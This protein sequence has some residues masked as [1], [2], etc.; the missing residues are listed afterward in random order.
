MNIERTWIQNQPPEQDELLNIAFQGEAGAHT[1]VI[2]CKTASGS[3]VALS[4][5][6]TGVYLGQNNVTV[7]LTGAISDGKAVVTLDD[8]CYAIP[9]KFIVSIYV[10]SDGVRPCVY[11]GIGYMFRTQTT[12][13]PTD[14]LPSVSEIASEAD[15]AETAADNAEASAQAAA[16]S[17]ASIPEFAFNVLMDWYKEEHDGQLTPFTKISSLTVDAT[18]LVSVGDFSPET[19]S[20]TALVKFETRGT[21]A[22]RDIVMDNPNARI[23]WSFTNLSGNATVTQGSSGIL[24]ITHGTNP[25]ATIMLKASVRDYT[26]NMSTLYTYLINVGKP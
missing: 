24:V 25:T 11:C 6:V 12:T 18:G 7:P 22:L 15:R 26:Y 16:A 1:F 3:S 10:E 19:T 17:A 8:N 21:F 2:G 23:V 5:T 20:Y 4:G 13:V 14:S 9:G